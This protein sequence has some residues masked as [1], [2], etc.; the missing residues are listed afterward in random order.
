MENHHFQWVHQ[1]FLWP[2]S[3]AKLLNYQRVIREPM[4]DSFENGVFFSGQNNGK[5]HIS[6]EKPW[7]QYCITNGLSMY[8]NMVCIYIYMPIFGLSK[9]Y[10]Q[11]NGCQDFPFNQSILLKCIVCG[12]I[13]ACG[14]PNHL[15]VLN[16]PPA[17]PTC[18]LRC[19]APS[20]K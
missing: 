14:W 2:P 16:L 18:P 8:S 5:P 1:L 6:W 4:E 20:C 13:C 10:I 19:G 17:H 15:D 7:F 12:I 9:W 3:I 11:C